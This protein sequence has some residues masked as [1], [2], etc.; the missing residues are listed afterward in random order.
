MIIGKVADSSF[1]DRSISMYIW[2]ERMPGLCSQDPLP[3][4][5]LNRGK[6][7][8]IWPPSSILYYNRYLKVCAR[9][10]LAENDD[11]NLFSDDI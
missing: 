8:L 5:A 11:D 9:C 6:G 4:A 1:E 10:H 7:C 2:I 3:E